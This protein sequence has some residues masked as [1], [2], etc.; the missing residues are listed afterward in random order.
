MA[1]GCRRTLGTRR[2]PT[3]LQWSH[4][5]DLRRIAW[6]GFDIG[7]VPKPIK[8][9]GDDRY[10]PTLLRLVHHFELLSDIGCG[11]CCVPL[12]EIKVG[13]G[14]LRKSLANGVHSS[15]A[16]TETACVLLRGVEL[17]RVSGKPWRNLD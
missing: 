17:F 16:T 11:T 15:V 2:P 14:V 6:F 3:V 4:W 5:A 12:A 7:H 10:D 1:T 8:A 9:W 13:M